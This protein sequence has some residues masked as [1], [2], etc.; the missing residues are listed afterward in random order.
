MK[1][2]VGQCPPAV[3]QT[4][5]ACWAV[6]ATSPGLLHSWPATHWTHP[7][8]NSHNASELLR[9]AENAD[10]NRNVPKSDT[11]QQ[12]GLPAM[13]LRK[14]V[15]SPP[16]TARV[17]HGKSGQCQQALGLLSECRQTGPSTV[18]WL[19]VTLSCTGSLART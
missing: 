9:D 18:P 19:S 7:Q 2:A 8:R 13:S 4:G 10:L 1:T 11:E 15:T 12:R 6:T 3:R 16:C 5:K 14:P 17:H